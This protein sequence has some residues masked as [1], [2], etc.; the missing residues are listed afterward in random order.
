MGGA[1]TTFWKRET[2]SPAMVLTSAVMSSMKRSG[3]RF[4][5]GDYRRSVKYRWWLMLFTWMPGWIEGGA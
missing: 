2:M 5:L 1:C 4:F 3:K